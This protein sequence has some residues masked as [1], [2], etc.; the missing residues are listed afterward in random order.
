MAQRL[1]RG[2]VILAVVLGVLFGGRALGVAE[3]ILVGLVVVLAL[4]ARRFIHGR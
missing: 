4:F 3:P 1:I 2:V